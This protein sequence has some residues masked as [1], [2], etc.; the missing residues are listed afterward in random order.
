[1]VIAASSRRLVRSAGIPFR[2]LA[3]RSLRST[4][5][6][7][8]L[9]LDPL[10]LALSVPQAASILARDRPAAILTTGGYVAIPVLTAAR[11]LGIPTI[12]W[13]GNVIP[14]RSVRATARLATAVAVSF[15]EACA[16]LAVAAGRCYL[17]GTPIRDFGD[18]DRG[19]ARVPGSGRDPAIGCC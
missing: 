16:A 9:V 8:H 14:G 7:V 2:R 3:L 18:V 12:L 5:R 17:T 19:R 15:P 4:D 13:E 1:M 11:L 6:S 10:R